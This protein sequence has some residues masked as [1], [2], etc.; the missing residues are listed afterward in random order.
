MAL[1]NDVEQVLE[2]VRPYLHRDGGDCQLIDVNGG[3]VK[4][5][6]MGVCKGCPSSS[7]TL[8]MLIEQKLMEELPGQII[9]V[10]EI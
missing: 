9:E 8:K 5:R 10:Q 3:I 7:M 1:F 4:V 6:F 2:D